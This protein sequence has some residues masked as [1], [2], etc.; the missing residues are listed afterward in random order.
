MSVQML[1]IK[2]YF[3]VVVC[4]LKI[5]GMPDDKVIIILPFLSA[6]LENKFGKNAI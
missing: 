2:G 4:S 6:G 5:G 1:Y 3:P